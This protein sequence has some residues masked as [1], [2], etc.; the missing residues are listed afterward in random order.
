VL[1]LRFPH[2]ACYRRALAADPVP[3]RALAWNNLLGFPYLHGYGLRSLGAL[4]R[5]FGLRCVRVD[6]DTLG[7]VADRSYARRARI[8]ERIVKAALRRRWRSDLGLAPWLDVELR[9]AAAP[10]KPLQSASAIS[11]GAWSSSG[12]RSQL[13][14][15]S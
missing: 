12:T 3:F 13:A 1:L 10:E 15:G 2:G 11:S 8:E 6:G 4:A 5:E 9:I 14:S 7:V